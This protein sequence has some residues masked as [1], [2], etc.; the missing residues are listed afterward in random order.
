MRHRSH[1][2]QAHLYGADA[3]TSWEY[4]EILYTISG[5]YNTGN[6]LTSSLNIQQADNFVSFPLIA[7]GDHI[8]IDVHPMYS[9]RDLVDYLVDFSSQSPFIS[10]VAH[11]FDDSEDSD[12][13]TDVESDSDAE[14]QYITIPPESPWWKAPPKSSSDN[15]S[16]DTLVDDEVDFEDAPSNHSLEEVLQKQ[17]YLVGVFH[18]ELRRMVPPGAYDD[19][20]LREVDAKLLLAPVEAFEEA[21]MSSMSISSKSSPTD[22]D[23][24]AFPDVPIDLDE[25]DEDQ[26]N[27]DLEE[28]EWVRVRSPSLARGT[29]F[30]TKSHFRN[31]HATRNESISWRLIL[32]WIIASL[33]TWS[34]IYIIASRGYLLTC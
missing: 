28:W 23:C 14:A 7:D 22:F 10:D 29:S 4:S 32:T 17:Q 18:D 3:C 21:C 2:M 12:S 26:T 20:W 30:L 25:G 1:Y 11:D 27:D 5:E 6:H 24:K 31:T 16:F 13:D 33:R 15:I 19:T 9:T 34:E 8:D